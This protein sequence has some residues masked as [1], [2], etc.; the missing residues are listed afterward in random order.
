MIKLL[1]DQHENNIGTS[2]SAAAQR[3]L[4]PTVDFNAFRRRMILGIGPIR[5]GTDS[6][7]GDSEVT[8]KANAAD[9]L[10]VVAR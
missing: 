7:R 3:I 2:L 6:D 1:S 5:S 4:W 9:T 10:A 8:T